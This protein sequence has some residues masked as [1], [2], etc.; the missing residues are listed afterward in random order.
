MQFVDAGSLQDVFLMNVE[1]GE[2]KKKQRCG[3]EKIFIVEGN[4]DT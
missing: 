2:R 3:G 1:S 4:E